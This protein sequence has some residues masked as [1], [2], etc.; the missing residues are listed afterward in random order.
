MEGDVFFDADKFNSW[1]SPSNRPSLGTNGRPMVEASVGHARA[2]GR[3]NLH[4][5][6]HSS[7]ISKSS[8]MRDDT[9]GKVDREEDDDEPNHSNSFFGKSTC[10]KITASIPAYHGVQHSFSSHGENDG[11]ARVLCDIDTRQ[12]QDNGNGTD[13]RMEFDEGSEITPSI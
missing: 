7:D 9:A 5:E 8:I 1:L 10:N 13:D 3:K 2:G 6:S 4:L 11:C 12:R